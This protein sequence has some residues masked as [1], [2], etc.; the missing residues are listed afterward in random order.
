MHRHFQSAV[1]ILALLT[2]SSANAQCSSEDVLAAAKMR[3]LD[4]LLMVSTL[5]CR[6]GGRDIL[7]E[8]AQFLDQNRSALLSASATL[9]KHYGSAAAYDRFVTRVANHYGA[10]VSGLT[11]SALAAI[12]SVARSAR[13]DTTKLVAIA[14][15]AGVAAL[16]DGD[17]CTNV[18]ER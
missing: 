12:A 1:A 16:L 5:R 7:P 8:Y 2:G 13:G 17:V 14:E 11:C 4:T 15:H 6:T 10:G 3:N 9:Q 18:A